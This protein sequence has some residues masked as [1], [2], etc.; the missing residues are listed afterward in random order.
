M[1]TQ[2]VTAAL[3]AIP[4]SN[5]A[6][7][8]AQQV[9]Q[10]LTL[11]GDT[12]NTQHAAATRQQLHGLLQQV[13]NALMNSGSL[14]PASVLAGLTLGVADCGATGT[15]NVATINTAGVY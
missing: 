6:Y 2:T 3:Q 13:V 10:K 12:K 15:M 1:T 11:A 9:L 4:P 8:F 14:P 7:Q 5:P